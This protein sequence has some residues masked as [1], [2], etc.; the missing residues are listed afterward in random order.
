MN[1]A[2]LIDRCLRHKAAESPYILGKRVEKAMELHEKIKSGRSDSWFICALCR[3][4]WP[5]ATVR[6]LNGEDL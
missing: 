3:V 4:M 1:A 5:C 6:I 2:W